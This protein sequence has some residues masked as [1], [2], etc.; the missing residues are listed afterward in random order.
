MSAPRGSEGLLGMLKSWNRRIRPDKRKALNKADAAIAGGMSDIAAWI[1]A[2]AVPM[3]A[4]LV[5]ISQIQRSGGTLLNQLFDGHSQIAAHP[6]ELKIGYPRTEIWPELDPAARPD[7]NFNRLFEG[8]AVKFARSGYTRGS[9]DPR[10]YKFVFSA[11]V[12]RAVFL[13]RCRAEP[14]RSLRDLLDHYFTSYFN[15]WL[16]YQGRLADKKFIAAFAPRLATSEE[17]VAGFFA[18]YPD[19]FLVQILR[20]PRGWY[21]ST[22]GHKRWTGMSPEQVVG[23]WVESAGAMLRNLERYGEDGRVIVVAFE[24]LVNETDRVMRSLSDRL[25]LPFEPVLAEPT[26]GGEVMEANSSFAVGAAGIIKAPVADRIRS[27]SDAERAMIEAKA[28]PLYEEIRARAARGRPAPRDRAAARGN[29][30]LSSRVSRHDA[31][32]GGTGDDL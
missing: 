28:L 25:G 9:K 17:S 20:D 11:E 16:D 19:G 15:A 4:P 12:Q 7:V 29:P 24:E 23:A 2:N 13:A 6:H 30:P 21:A 10:R 31:T 8:K 32:K 5:L 3:R 27:L 26:F 1:G 22:K 14:P 18:C